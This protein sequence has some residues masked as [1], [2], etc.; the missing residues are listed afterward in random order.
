MNVNNFPEKYE[1]YCGKIFLRI[2]RIVSAKIL[3]RK[4][5]GFASLIKNK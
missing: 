2:S 1:I 4:K 3:G 5:R